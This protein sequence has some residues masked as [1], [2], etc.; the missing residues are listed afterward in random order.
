MMAERSSAARPVRR[1]GHPCRPDRRT[2]LRRRLADHQTWSHLS[3]TITPLACLTTLAV[4]GGMRIP[5]CLEQS[6][7]RPRSVSR[8]D[9]CR[10]GARWTP[11][12]GD[13]RRERSGQIS[14]RFGRFARSQ[15]GPCINIVV[16]WF[17]IWD[18]NVVMGPIDASPGGA[19]SSPASPRSEI[20]RCRTAEPTP[21]DRARC[22]RGLILRQVCPTTIRL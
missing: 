1:S 12:R 5:R 16:V 18:I 20:A 7:G 21:P 6:G 17:W 9:L 11:A 22:G 14:P 8:R 3:P 19:A 2:P 13:R 10:C 4:P 15:R